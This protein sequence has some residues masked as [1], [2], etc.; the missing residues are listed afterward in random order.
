L[1]VIC[2]FEPHGGISTNSAHET[3]PTP[4]SQFVI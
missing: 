2:G 1:V 3:D 4:L